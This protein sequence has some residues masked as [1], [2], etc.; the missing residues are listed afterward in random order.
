ML[1]KINLYVLDNKGKIVEDTIK[2]KE[3]NSEM[4]AKELKQFANKGKY[5]NI[6]SEEFMVH[7]VIKEEDTDL[8]DKPFILY[9]I[10]LN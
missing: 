3:S 2:V 1:Y 4:T 10:K 8:I 5:K 7:H 9:T 6:S